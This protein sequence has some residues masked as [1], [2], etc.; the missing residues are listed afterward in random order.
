[1]AKEKNGSIAVAASV[2]RSV[3]HGLRNKMVAFISKKQPTNVTSIYKALGLEQSVASQHLKILRK[4]GI[5]QF[6]R[7]GK[8]ILYRVNETRLKQIND[9]AAQLANA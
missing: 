5:L 4:S 8:Q 2:L 6:Q 3:N 7:E 9:L 1:M